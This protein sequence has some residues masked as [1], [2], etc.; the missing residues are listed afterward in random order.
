MLKSLASTNFSLVNSLI[1]LDFPAVEFLADAY[2]P[3]GRI[4]GPEVEAR[5][6]I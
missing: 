6:G 4:A 1:W 3:D 2:Q 5:Y